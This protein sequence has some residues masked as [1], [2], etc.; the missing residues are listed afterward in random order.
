MTDTHHQVYIGTI[1]LEHNRWEEQCSPTYQLSDWLARFQD[2]GFAGMELWEN[3]MLLADGQEQQRLVDSALPV[4]IYNSYANFEDGEEEKWAKSAE[5]VHCL[6]AKAVKFNLGKD[7]ALK[8]T[9]LRNVRKWA[10]ML[11]QDCRLLCEC[12]P[13]TA[14]ETPKQAADMFQ[15]L[16]SKRV[17]AIIHPFFCLGDLQS[18]F[19]ELGSAI[20]H[21]HVQIRDAQ[22][23]FIRL[24]QA[25]D[26]AK[27]R[28][29]I[30][31][32]CGFPGTYTLE[33]AAGTRSGA[34]RE[35]LYRA[36]LEDFSFLKEYV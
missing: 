8:E 10:E 2:D 27:R 14:A 31:K 30:M 26:R 18:W 29:D 5:A 23:Q 34:D 21:A 28:L 19:D 36:A 4:S 35:Q 24:N 25:P 1:L 22:D 20:T 13:G 32:R 16:D 17:E 9:Y 33:F 7:E 15:A 6:K 11:P 3:H 12:H